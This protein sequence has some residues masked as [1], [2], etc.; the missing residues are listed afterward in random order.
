MNRFKHTAALLAAVWGIGMFSTCAHTADL[1]PLMLEAGVTQSFYDDDSKPAR[2]NDDADA[3]K[4]GLVLKAGWGDFPV[5]GVISYESMSI[6]LVGQ[7]H[8]KPDIFTFGIGARKQW[9]KFSVFLETGYADVTAN[10]QRSP[11]DTVS[12]VA[13]TSLVGT[14]NVYD[15]PVPV[16]PRDYE[17]SYSLDG[18][19]FARLGVGYQLWNH[20]KL[21]AAYRWLSV[22]EEIAIWDTYRREND[23]GYWREDGTKELHSVEVS[24][25]YTF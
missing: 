14:H 22:D 10:A 13:Y 23:L 12:E 7:T 20:V 6:A 9:D 2:L 19:P 25:L 16:N 21:T 18:G 4:N 24:L 5:Y 11:Y 3:P 1:D 15:K 8:A 17:A